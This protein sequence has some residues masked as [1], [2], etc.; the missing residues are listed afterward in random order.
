MGGVAM[1][2]FSMKDGFIKVVLGWIIVFL[3]RLIP[4]RP[5]NIEPVLATLMPFSKKYGIASGFF[6]AFLSIALFDIA[7]GQLGKWTFCTALIYGI[8]GLTSGVYFRNRESNPINY[9][10][11][12]LAGTIIYDAISGPGVAYFLNDY[13]HI[14]YSFQQA[15]IGQIPFTVLHLLGNGAMALVVSPIIYRWVVS[16]PNLETN[17]IICKFAFLGRCN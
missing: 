6:F 9:L 14:G 3:L 11:F 15:L 8:L 4:F 13:S 5:P 1:N 12:S 2:K 16:N 17:V 7:V 10:K